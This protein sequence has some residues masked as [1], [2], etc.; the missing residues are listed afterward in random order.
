MTPLEILLVTVL[1]IVL[2]VDLYKEQRNYTKIKMLES[3]IAI[4]ES[5]LK[6]KKEELK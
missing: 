5:M 4:A 2:V 6:I 3:R 1:I